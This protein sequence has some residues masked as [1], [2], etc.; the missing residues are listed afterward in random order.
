MP[1]KYFRFVADNFLSQIIGIPIRK[2]SLLDFLSVNKE[3]CD[4]VMVNI[5]LSHSDH[6]MLQSKI[7]HLMKKKDKR[8]AI[9]DLVRANFKLFRD[10]CS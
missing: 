10:L 8:V 6:E 7:L 4:Y 9:L 5:C 2:D 3:V 1:W